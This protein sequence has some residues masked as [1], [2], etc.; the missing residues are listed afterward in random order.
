MRWNPAGTTPRG[1]VLIIPPFGEEMNRARRQ[2]ALAGQAFAAQGLGTSVLDPTGTGDSDG[3]FADA[4][5]DLWQDDIRRAIR[6]IAGRSM[7]PLTV[8]G[9]RLG[10]LLVQGAI[11]GVDQPPRNIVL[12]QPVASGEAF[13]TQILRIRL[14]A[15]LGGAGASETTQSLRQR[16]SG[17]ETL[18]IA[19]YPITSA[20]AAGLDQLRLAE[21]PKGCRTAW[22]EVGSEALGEIGPAG[23]RWIERWRQAGH[24]VTAATVAGPPFWSLMET[25]TA[26]QM[27]AATLAF[28]TEP[29]TA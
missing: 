17:G 28:I 6:V 14:A 2:L 10:A 12:W 20:L 11:G 5:I 29:V 24:S 21:P 1:E 25:E 4:T 23:M 15:A 26:P 22:I 13:L 18:E 3:A 27:I 19:G 7:A 8:L 16:L 9:L